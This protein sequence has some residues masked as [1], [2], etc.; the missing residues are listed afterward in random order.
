MSAPA[1]DGPLQGVRVLEL[2]TLI[3]GPFAGRLLADLGAELIKIERPDKPDPMR[4]W[5]ADYRGRNL[6]WPIQSRNKKL[7]TLD[8][9]NGRELFLELVARSDVVLENFRPGTLE[10]WGVG[11][12][13]LREVN[14]GIVVARVSG[15]G[16]T[17]PYAARAGFASVAEA[18]AGLRHLNGYPG[19][20]PPRTGL[21]LG[22]SLAPCSRPS[23]CWRRCCSATGADRATARSST[24]R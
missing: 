24:S 1:S 4:E 12:D 18:M 19:E 2:G 20:P 15:Y 5:G 23:A 17:G 22:D 9:R 13:V 3:A 21:S 8:L 10:R 7:I 16:Q 6:W 14:P 11:P